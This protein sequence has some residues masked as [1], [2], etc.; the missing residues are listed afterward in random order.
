MVD[1]V[2]R[3]NGNRIV[4]APCRALSEGKQKSKPAEDGQIHPRVMQK[5]IDMHGAQSARCVREGE[6][7]R[8]RILPTMIFQRTDT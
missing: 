2:T 3:P 6:L 7:A 1:S 8:I 4:G 5:E